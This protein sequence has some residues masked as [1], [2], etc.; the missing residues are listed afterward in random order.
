MVANSLPV[1]TTSTQGVG[2][3]GQNIFF[4]KVVMLDIKVKGKGH[5]SP[6]NRIVCSYTHPQPMGGSKGQNSFVSESLQIK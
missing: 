1:D 2:S 6:C 3:K 5:S 4:L